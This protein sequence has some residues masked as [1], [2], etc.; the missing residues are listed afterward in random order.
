MSDAC[1]LLF[2]KPARPGRVKTRLI[3]GPGDV[4]SGGLTAA[5]AARLHQAVLG[6]L[7]ARLSPGDFDLVLA[8]AVDPGEAPPDS[9][10]AAVRQRGADLGERLW[11]GLSEA[12]ETHELA[13][14]VGSDHPELPLG[15]VEQG[16]SRLGADTDVV[17]GPA[18]DGGYYF[19]G[20]TAN[21]LRREIFD[22]IAWSTPTVLDETLD[23]C[24]SLG[25]R[26][27]LLEPGS[28]V[29][30]PTDLESLA[31]RLSA[32]PGGQETVACPRTERLLREWGLFAG[33]V[34][35]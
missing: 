12:L 35:A 33:E 9:G 18:L 25:L 7:T 28:D 1:L 16:F 29:D 24:R 8:W 30:T 2:T 10:L 21:G 4:E 17:L 23:R 13:A 15:I 27:E 31:R 32:A 20:A 3:G 6:D 26:V 5:Q 34:T 11:H 22:G 14:A 19:L